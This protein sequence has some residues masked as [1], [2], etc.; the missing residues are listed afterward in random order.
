[1]GRRMVNGHWILFSM[2]MVAIG[3]FWEVQLDLRKGRTVLVEQDKEK[4]QGKRGGLEE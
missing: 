3:G 1:M 4:E 2:K